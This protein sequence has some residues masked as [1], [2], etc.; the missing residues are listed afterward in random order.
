MS[1]QKV[2][3]QLIHGTSSD[4]EEGGIYSD[5]KLCA[6]EMALNTTTGEVRFG[7]VENC[8]WNTAI[9]V[10]KT[11]WDNIKNSIVDVPIEEILLRLDS[12]EKQI[13]NL[14][15]TKLDKES[16]V[17]EELINELFITKNK[18]GK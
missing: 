15:N 10:N 7:H 11:Y 14:Q 17:E 4:W 1:K 13:E 2:R 18:E 12:V 6:G 5:L 8:T 16:I 9:R 3:I